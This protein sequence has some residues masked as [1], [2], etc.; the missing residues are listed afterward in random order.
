MLMK[1]DREWENVWSSAF[2]VLAAAAMLFT[3]LFLS[4]QANATA[5]FRTN[6]LHVIE[7]VQKTIVQS[8]VFCQTPGAPLAYL[9]SGEVSPELQAECV[10]LPYTIQAVLEA[11]GP[12]KVVGEEIYAVVRVSFNAGAEKVQA[13]TLSSFSI[14][15]WNL[16][17]E[18]YKNGQEA[19]L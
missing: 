17:Q 3:I 19:G 16:I 4:S 1:F 9:K 5:Q 8:S 11:V 13:Y 2:I 14:T 15:E 6:P 18:V 12:F 7:Q 10:A